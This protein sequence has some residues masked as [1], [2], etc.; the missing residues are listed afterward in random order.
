MLTQRRPNPRDFVALES[1]RKQ[2]ARLFARGSLRLASIARQLKVSRQSVSRLVSGLEETGCSR[3]ASGRPS[4]E[5]AAAKHKTVGEARGGAEEGRAVPWFPGG[6][7]DVAACGHGDRAA[8]GNTV[9]SRSHVEGS[10][11]DEVVLSEAGAAGQGEERGTGGIL[12]S[13][14]VA[15]GKKNAAQQ[16]AWIF[17]EDESGFSQQPSIRRTWAPRGETPVLKARGITGAGRRSRRPWDLTGVGI[18][19]GCWPGPSRTVTTPRV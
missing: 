8:H 4:R 1:R 19:H 14:A 18:G 10:G 11:N 7:V 6:S 17:F 3:A 13:R 12:E 9:S 2:A 5:D 15:G 16:R